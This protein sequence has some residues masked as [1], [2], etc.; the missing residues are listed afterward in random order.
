MKKDATVIR[1]LRSKES[2]ELEVEVEV[3]KT[4][5]ATSKQAFSGSSQATDAAC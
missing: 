5:V 4:V 1:L 2:V 3:Q